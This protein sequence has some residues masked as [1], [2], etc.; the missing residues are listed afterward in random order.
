[1]AY[2]EQHMM[3]ISVMRSTKEIKEITEKPWGGLG[4]KIKKMS[5]RNIKICFPYLFWYFVRNLNN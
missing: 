4:D 1:M 2:A 3:M 5:E